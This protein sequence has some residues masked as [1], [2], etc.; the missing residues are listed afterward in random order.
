[1]V[2]TSF[3]G[4]FFC[5]KFNHFEFLPLNFQFKNANIPE[6]IAPWPS[7]SSTPEGT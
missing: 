5:L 4:V 2:I 7:Q 3:L 1:M 6:K